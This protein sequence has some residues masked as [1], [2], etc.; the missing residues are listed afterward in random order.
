MSAM[1]G[2]TG[3]YAVAACYG[4]GAL[5]VLVPTFW[6][7]R[8]ILPM[9]YWPAMKNYEAAMWNMPR[10]ASML[11]IN[12]NF[13]HSVSFSQVR[14]E[15]CNVA[16]VYMLSAGNLANVIVAENAGSFCE[17]A[18]DGAGDPVSARMVCE[19]MRGCRWRKT[20]LTHVIQRC[21]N[22]KKQ[23]I[24]NGLA[25]F[26]VVLGVV[27]AV[28]TCG[29]MNSEKTIKK[30]KEL[31]KKRGQAATVAVAGIAMF[32]LAFFLFIIGTFI[33]YGALQSDSDYPF[34][35]FGSG[36]AVFLVGVVTA[37]VAVKL[38]VARFLYQRSVVNG[39]KANK[40]ALATEN[41]ALANEEWGDGGG[42]W[43]DGGGDWGDG[44]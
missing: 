30:P 4:V 29:L 43:G 9:M 14:I 1:M 15:V 31:L 41:Q 39:N 12:D 38:T 40:N 22:Y 10:G 16:E 34:P 36:C 24:I 3:Q 6:C 2:P 23:M 19:A 20:C 42:D 25:V 32:I 17:A 28:C 35:T 37:A 26:L 11:S 33:V 8:C 18:G 5:V 21:S 27:F 44:S 7:G 13:Q